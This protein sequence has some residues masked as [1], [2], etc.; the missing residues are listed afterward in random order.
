MT[1]FFRIRLSF[2]ISFFRVRFFACYGLGFSL[3]NSS[4]ATFLLSL[5]P[6]CH[7]IPFLC[8][9]YQGK[10]RCNIS[11]SLFAPSAALYSIAGFPSL[12]FS[13]RVYAVSRSA[14]IILVFL[15]AVTM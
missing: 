2:F 6:F 5:A 7:F 9:I 12:F 11:V 13:S 10:Y 14:V 8:I 15:T 1:F 3:S 4:L